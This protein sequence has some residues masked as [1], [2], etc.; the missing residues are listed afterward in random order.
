[1]TQTKDERYA[2][3]IEEGLREIVESFT[4]EIGRR[5]SLHE[6]LQILTWGLRGAPDD[7]LSDSHPANVSALRPRFTKG[8]KTVGSAEGHTS[9]VDD[10]NDSAFS[11]ATEVL[12]KVARSINADEGKP[13]TLAR[14][15]ALITTSLCETGDSLISDD[16][17]DLAAIQPEVSRRGKT[18]VRPGDIVA[19][20]AADGEFFTG[21]VLERNA[22]GTAYGLFKGKGPLRRFSL[23]AQPPIMRFPVYTGDE[24][25]ASGRWRILGHDDELRKLFPQEPEIY[26]RQQLLAA[27]PKIGKYGS[28]ETASGKMRDLTHEEADALGLL[29]GEYQQA[30]MPEE[31]EQYLQ[32]HATEQDR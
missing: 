27:G 7:I 17:S 1:M 19:I 31:L 12:A 18:A 25:V 8:R 29:T 11:S 10:L 15:L 2:V 5:P 13:P 22:F 6:L 21:V 20:P 24:S 32:K 30:Y 4:L 9:S 3:A 16:P 26:H 28:A 23:G 14:L